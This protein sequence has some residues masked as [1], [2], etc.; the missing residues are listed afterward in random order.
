MVGRI[1][2]EHYTAF[3][4]TESSG[5]AAAVFPIEGINGKLPPRSSLMKVN[6]R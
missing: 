1:F 4:R 2:A 6:D 3:D 5:Y